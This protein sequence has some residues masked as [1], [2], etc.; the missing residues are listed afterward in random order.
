[1]ETS[2]DDPLVYISGVYMHVWVHATRRKV[3]GLV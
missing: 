1:M 3:G 2:L